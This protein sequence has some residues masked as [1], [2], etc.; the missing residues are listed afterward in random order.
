M[1]YK[2]DYQ[3]IIVAKIENKKNQ[4]KETKSLKT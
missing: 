4:E 3:W 1:N 2:I